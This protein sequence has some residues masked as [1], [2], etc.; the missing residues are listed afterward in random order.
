[1]QKVTIAALAP[2]DRAA[3]VAGLVEMAVAARPNDDVD[4]LWF[5]DPP[6]RLPPVDAVALTD[7]FDA[8][9]IDVR[10]VPSLEIGRAVI[11]LA[12][13]Q[14]A[15]EGPVR[16][17]ERIVVLSHPESGFATLP[18]AALAAAA[19]R[20]TVELLADRPEHAAEAPAGLPLKVLPRGRA[21]AD[22]V[23]RGQLVI[24]PARADAVLA[25]AMLRSA[26]LLDASAPSDDW[27]FLWPTDP[28]RLVDR[29]AGYDA[30]Q[31][32][33]LLF[34]WKRSAEAAARAAIEAWLA[35]AVR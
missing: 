33:P 30:E 4:V 6:R 18:R 22:A 24:A 28:E 17:V 25:N 2:R 35:A 16:T 8:E 11:D 15:H 7:G 5:S 14:P 1:M 3:T 10:D 19:E 26:V 29:I 23:L 27:P 13:F 20:W 12:L 21:W 31:G 32:G 34:N 9:R